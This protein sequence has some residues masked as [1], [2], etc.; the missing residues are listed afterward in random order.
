MN[1]E[2]VREVVVN[3]LDSIVT[4]CGFR[5]EREQIQEEN[6]QQVNDTIDEILKLHKPPTVTRRA[7]REFALF[8]AAGFQARCPW[9]PGATE[10]LAEFLVAQGVEVTDEP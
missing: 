6:E 7:L 10:E 5:D 2:Q 3:L 9:I 8:L 1:R 4:P